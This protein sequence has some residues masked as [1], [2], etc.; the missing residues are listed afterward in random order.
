MK[1]YRGRRGIAPLILNLS[2]DGGKWL[3]SH[4]GYFTPQ[5]RTMVP[6]EQEAG[7]TM[8]LVWTF[9][10]LEYL[11]LLLRFESWTV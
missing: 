1:A 11:L 5:E 7:W 4:L 3:S 9:W 2:L 6:I 10:G 8:E